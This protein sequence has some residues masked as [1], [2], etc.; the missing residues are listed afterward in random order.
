MYDLNKLR[1]FVRVAEQ[2]SFTKAGRD[3]RTTAS[4]VSK[5]VQELETQMGVTLFH[6]STRQVSLTEAGESLYENCNRILSELE[7]ALTASQDIHTEAQGVLRLQVVGGFA[8]HILAPLLPE[9]LDAYPR[10]DI[11]LVTGRPAISREFSVD[12]IISHKP[13]EDMGMAYHALGDIP[14]A[15]CAAPGYFAAHGL[16]TNPQD[17]AQ[18]NC[19]T[20]TIYNPREWP[21]AVD[22][23]D[24]KV[25]VNGRFRS[26]TSEVL[27]QLA[28]AGFGIVRLPGYTVRQ[29]IQRGELRE[30]F[31]EFSQ[32]P[33]RMHAYYTAARYLPSKT[34]AFI[35]FLEQAFQVRDR[36]PRA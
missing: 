22:G 34:K 21:F 19:L 4:A 5:Q 7:S 24:T 25:R 2:L 18:H 26:D 36:S 13:M 11:E 33:Q 32:S 8:Q 16:P 10:M 17:L 35:E 14:W 31:A 12:L 20:H 9:F 23:R 27:L 15:T 3:L 1:A 29:S 30:I 28:V 6:R